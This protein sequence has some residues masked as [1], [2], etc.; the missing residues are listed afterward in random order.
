M[1]ETKSKSFAETLL[2]EP[3][4]GVPIAP[5]EAR[6]GATRER[7]HAA[8]ALVLRLMFKDGRRAPGL[9]WALFGGRS[10]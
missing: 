1:P 7:Q 2:R 5:E 3:G 10:V 4:R 9:P 8:Q 6:E